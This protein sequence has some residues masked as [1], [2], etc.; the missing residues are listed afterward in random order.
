[1]RINIWNGSTY[2]MRSI[3]SYCY[4]YDFSTGTEFSNASGVTFKRTDSSNNQWNYWNATPTSGKSQYT[5]TGT[6]S[7]NGSWTN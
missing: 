4:V 7:N 3:G 1:M 6:G 2:D 5:S